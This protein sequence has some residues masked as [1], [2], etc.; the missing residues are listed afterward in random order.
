[1]KVLLNL[2][3]VVE[4]IFHQQ[5]IYHGG[6]RNRVIG[7]LDHRVIETITCHKEGEIKKSV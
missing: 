4:I 3:E 2:S 5:Q 7:S 1:L 6:G